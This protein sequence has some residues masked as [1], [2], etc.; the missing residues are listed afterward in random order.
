MSLVSAR[1]V[2]GVTPPNI[3]Y[4]TATAETAEITRNRAA[5]AKKIKPALDCA[6]RWSPYISPL[7]L[8]AGA[9]IP[10]DADNAYLRKV[11]A[12]GGFPAYEKAHRMR[13]T[14]TCARVVFPR[15]PVDAVSH[16]VAFAFHTGYY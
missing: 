13:L 3:C 1:T 10:P 12:A 8:A 4:Y 11:A 5:I 9:T 6:I 15:L 16:V 2:G 14:A 7:L